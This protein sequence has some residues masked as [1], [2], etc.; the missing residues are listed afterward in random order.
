MKDITKSILQG[1]FDV[2]KEF[3]RSMDDIE[4]KDTIMTIA[5]ETE[6][7]SVYSFIQYMIKETERIFW[8]ELAIDI[9]VNPLCFIEG[10]YSAALY[11]SRDLLSKDRNVENLEML[12]FFH[13]IPE[14][15]VDKEEAESIAEE[16]LKIE[17]DNKAALEIMRYKNELS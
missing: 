6:S 1:K 16:I 9:L 11:H 10:A 12:I 14:K 15:L 5:Y 3:C 17:P 4:I 2:A 7:I 13:N 8:I